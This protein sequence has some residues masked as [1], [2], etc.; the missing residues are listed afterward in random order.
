MPFFLGWASRVYYSDNGSTTIEIA[1]KIAFRKFSLDHGIMARS[2]N[3]TRNERNIKLK[4][5]YGHTEREMCLWAISI[6]FW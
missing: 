5:C 3:S 6:M 1:L 2:E 4:V